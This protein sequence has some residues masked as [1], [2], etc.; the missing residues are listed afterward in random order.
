ML[1][2]STLSD[3]KFSSTKYHSITLDGM[4]SKPQCSHMKIKSKNSTYH[5]G[6]W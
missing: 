1:V 5:I 3:L 4:L 2:K 6:L